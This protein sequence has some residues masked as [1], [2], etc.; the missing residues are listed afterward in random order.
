MM[1]NCYQKKHLF[2]LQE[3]HEQQAVDIY[4]KIS[5]LPRYMNPVNDA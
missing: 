4:T 2:E 5:K 1:F 3:G